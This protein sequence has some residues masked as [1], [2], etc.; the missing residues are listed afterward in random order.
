M[1][2]RRGARKKGVPQGPLL[3][4]PETHKKLVDAV[5]MGAPVPTAA[6]YAGIS[7]RS[8]Q[9]W[10]AKGRDEQNRRDD[11]GAPDHDLDPYVDLF[12]DVLKARADAGMRN[13]GILQRVAQGGSVLEE[14]TK[15]YRDPETG[16]YVEEH[17]VKRQPA[18]WRAATFWLER[19]QRD[20]WGKDAV[21]VEIS[22][23]GGGAVE[24]ET[25]V[26]VDDLAAKISTNLAALAA[27]ALPELEAG[28]GELGVDPGDP[29]IIDADIVDA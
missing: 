20:E 13:V 26:N 22:G 3:L 29:R 2:A 28:P 6:T 15:R 11:G 10:C 19:Q 9:T 1:G 5:R 12:A 7:V 8:F 16:E 27:A 23:P 18:D 25:T 17:T 14:T 21:H 4:S 24:I